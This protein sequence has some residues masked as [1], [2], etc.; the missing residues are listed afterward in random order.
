MQIYTTNAGQV[1][2]SPVAHP[3]IS[4]FLC[5]GWVAKTIGERAMDDPQLPYWDIPVLDVAGRKRML[6][7]VAHPGEIT[8]QVPPGDCARFTPESIEQLRRVAAY[9]RAEA[10]KGERW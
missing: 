10:L 5:R 4:Q 2:Y 1:G 3:G 9:A 7:V 6:R 8:L